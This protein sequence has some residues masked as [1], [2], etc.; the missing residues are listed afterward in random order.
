MRRAKT[1]QKTMAMNTLREV[2]QST[3]HRRPWRRSLTATLDQWAWDMFAYIG[4]SVQQEHVGMKRQQQLDGSCTHF[5]CWNSAEP[6]A[7][8]ANKF[9]TISIRIRGSIGEPVSELVLTHVQQ[10][11]L[12][13]CR[14]VVKKLYRGSH[15]HPLGAAPLMSARRRFKTVA[16]VVVAN[17][18]IPGQTTAISML[19]SLTARIGRTLPLIVRSRTLFNLRPGPLVV[20]AHSKRRN[21]AAPRR[22]RSSEVLPVRMM[23]VS[24]ASTLSLEGHVEDC[25]RCVG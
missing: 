16:V 3:P 23:A 7:K 1:I 13:S 11:N 6:V 15:H 14:E 19:V 10:E 18:I 20:G 9:R 2:A 22:T 21:R 12:P 4:H 5:T 17:T 25:Q 24:Y 8:G